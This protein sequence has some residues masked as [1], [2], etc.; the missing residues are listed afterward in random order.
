MDSFGQMNDGLGQM[1]DGFGQMTFDTLT[2][3]RSGVSVVSKTSAG[4]SRSGASVQGGVSRGGGGR[5]EGR[6]EG[7]SALFLVYCFDHIPRPANVIPRCCQV[8]PRTPTYPLPS[9]CD[10]PCV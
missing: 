8:P 6:L 4:S 2:R 3:P 1:N 10:L 5:L 7:S 9:Y